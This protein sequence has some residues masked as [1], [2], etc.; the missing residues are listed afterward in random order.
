M[1]RLHNKRLD[2]TMLNIKYLVVLANIATELCVKQWVIQ[3]TKNGKNFR[4]RKSE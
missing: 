1:H 4:S 2:S 3:A